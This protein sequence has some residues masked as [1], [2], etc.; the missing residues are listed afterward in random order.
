MKIEINKDLNS[1]VD[2]DQLPMQRDW[3]DNTFDR[4]AYNC[5][6]VSLANRLGWGLS[7][8]KDVEFIWDGIESSED[9][10]VK[11][12]QGEEFATTSRANRTVSFDTGLYISPETNISILTMPP[13][14]IFLDGIQ[15]VSTII[16]TS[17]LIG[18]LS[19]AIMVTTPNKTIKIPSGQIIASIVPI[20][21][22]EMNNSELIIKSGAP[23]FAS[24]PS[25]I[26]RI[27]DRGKAS[28]KSNSR[29]IWT[30]FYRNAVDHD[31]EK[32]GEHESKKI[33]MRVNNEN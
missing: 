20:S 2:I 30:N 27:T 26:K 1:Y 10:H 11:I 21:L 4:H 23:K 15:C 33:I 12:I 29:G 17:A 14:N 28:Q 3:M 19:I 25:W 13:P 7:F 5:F 31:G 9:G 18:P 22:K 32:Y 8:K 6:P 24:D 16:S